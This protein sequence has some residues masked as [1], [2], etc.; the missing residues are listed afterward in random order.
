MDWSATKKRAKRRGSDDGRKRA[1]TKKLKLRAAF[2]D[3]D[4]IVPARK[5]SKP[6]QFANKT[7]I[8]EGLRK[9]KESP[10]I[11]RTA[12]YFF[13][14]AAKSFA[15]GDLLSA[16]NALDEALNIDASHLESLC[17]RS[18]C[19]RRLLRDDKLETDDGGELERAM[20]QIT[21]IEGVLR[22]DLPRNRRIAECAAVA[23]A[24]E[25]GILE[26]LFALD[27]LRHRKGIECA[28]AESA[29][30]GMANALKTFHRKNS[31]GEFAE[32]IFEL[33]EMN[34]LSRSATESVRVLEV[35]IS[36]LSADSAMKRKEFGSAIDGYG[37][38]LR[39]FDEAKVDAADE[40][41]FLKAQALS[42]RSVAFF[43]DRRFEECIAD[44][45][46]ILSSSD[47]NCKAFVRRGAANLSLWQLR[48]SDREF[49][50]RALRDYS[51]AAEIDAE[52]TA[53]VKKI[54]KLVQRLSATERK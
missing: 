50:E 5:D 8:A 34:A 32:G 42:N 20:A 10:R 29:K 47:S 49:L 2:S 4:Y 30:I 21:D 27:A 17:L 16:R 52:Y 18:E 51:S 39:H 25:K 37:A 53:H 22:A 48:Q 45:D 44:C 13:D 33:I 6:P 28:D 46:A 35:I 7:L 15:N 3:W 40:S 11:P 38:V 24:F 14:V 19:A 9:E 26:T 54:E 43:A 36:K 41:F 12:Q 31:K 1:I 23:V